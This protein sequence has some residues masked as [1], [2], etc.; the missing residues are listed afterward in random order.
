ML[1]IEWENFCTD[2]TVVSDVI[3]IPATSSQTLESVQDALCSMNIEV[4]V[5]FAEIQKTVPGL[6]TLMEKVS[7]PKATICVPLKL[8]DLVEIYNRCSIFNGI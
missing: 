7:T 5:L 3:I 6:E 8:L 4:D 1:S 2:L